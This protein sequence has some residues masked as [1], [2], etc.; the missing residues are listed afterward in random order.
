M[1]SAAALLADLTKENWA[2]VFDLPEG[3]Y[4]I[5]C[6]DGSV[7]PGSDRLFPR[8]ER[9][10]AREDLA[11]I[12]LGGKGLIYAPADFKIEGAVER[13]LD[14]MLAPLLAKRSRF[15]GRNRLTPIHGFTL[16]GVNLKLLIGVGSVGLTALLAP[17]AWQTGMDWLHPKPK[18]SFVRPPGR[19]ETAAQPG[20][21]LAR[22]TSAILTFPSLAGADLVSSDC[23]PGSVKYHYTVTSSVALAL[24]Q[25]QKAPSG[26]QLNPAAAGKLEM[27]CPVESVAPRGPGPLL[28]EAAVT[29]DAWRQL[30]MLGGQLQLDPGIVIS[31]SAPGQAPVKA[32]KFTLDISLPPVTFADRAEQIQ[33]LAI[34]QITYNA[35]Q[36]VSDVGAAAKSGPQASVAA[37][38]KI[39]GEIY[40]Q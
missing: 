27:S 17:M 9:N 38:W 2:A 13:K 19:W 23:R 29:Q 24:I 18:T 37:V 12:A 26:C 28:T 21:L 14:E 3:F 4:L 31:V 10:A 15:S 33:G 11:N 16:P 1:L 5:T 20:P 35:K 32:Q 7:W 39:E 6:R 36:V 34:Q 25:Q 22:C 40:V 8:I 30:G